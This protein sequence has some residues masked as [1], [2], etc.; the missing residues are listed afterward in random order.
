MGTCG[1]SER[2]GIFIR[3]RSWVYTVVDHI[4]SKYHRIN[5]IGT[6]YPNT[7]VKFIEVPRFSILLIIN[8]KLT[9]P[10]IHLRYMIQKF[11]ASGRTKFCYQKN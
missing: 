8:S 3:V 10:R 7:K 4:V 9:L 6:Q 11:E 2:A 5:T 1:I